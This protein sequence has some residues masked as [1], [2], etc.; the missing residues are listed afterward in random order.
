[1]GAMKERAEIEA[2]EVFATNLKDLLMAAPAGP[3]ATL[4]L[5]PGFTYRFRKSRW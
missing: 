1:M 2:I 4:G 3:R 5:D